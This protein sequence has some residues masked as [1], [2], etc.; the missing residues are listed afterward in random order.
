MWAYIIVPKVYISDLKSTKATMT[1][2]VP[3]FLRVFSATGLKRSFSM[4]GWQ[5]LGVVLGLGYSCCQ[6]APSIRQFLW[7][8]GSY[9][10]LPPLGALH[11]PSCFGLPRTTWL[12]FYLFNSFF[13][14]S[15]PFTHPCLQNLSEVSLELALDVKTWKPSTETHQDH[16][17]SGKNEK[18]KNSVFM[19]RSEW[20]KLLIMGQRSLVNRETHA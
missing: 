14:I 20:R 17:G 2:V 12:V 8:W 1:P 19:R 11:K 13:S 3:L 6:V 4:S 7:W 18:L 15:F 5:C 9:Q 10:S 16:L